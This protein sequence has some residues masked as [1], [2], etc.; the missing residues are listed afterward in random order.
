MQNFASTKLAPCNFFFFSSRRRHTRLQGDWSSDVCSSDL[1]KF[2]LTAQQP[3]IPS[4]AEA[5]FHRFTDP[6]LV[7][8]STQPV[9]AAREAADERRAR[10]IAQRELNQKFRSSSSKKASPRGSS[11]PREMTERFSS[12]LAADATPRIR[13]L[14]RAWPSPA[15]IMGGSRV[16]WKRKFPLRCKRTF[17]TS[18]TKTT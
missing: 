16:C 15:K 8:E 5:Q 10:F 14:P 2:V 13:P 11:L 1:G 9:P 7:E 6:E 17:K 12:Q 18:F 4:R 3:E